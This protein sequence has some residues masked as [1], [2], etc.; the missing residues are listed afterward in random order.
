[1]L[2]DQM[3]RPTLAANLKRVLHSSHSKHDLDKNFFLRTCDVGRVV[4]QAVVLHLALN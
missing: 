3:N 1:M 4:R 2:S